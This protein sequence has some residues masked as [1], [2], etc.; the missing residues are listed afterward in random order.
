MKIYSIYKV[1]NKTNGKTYIGFDSNWPT[2][3]YQHK[4]RAKKGTIKYRLYLAINKY[5][6]N[7]FEWSI[8]YQSKELEHTLKVMEPY[9]IMEYNSMASGYN[10]TLG[11]DGTPGHLRDPKIAKEHSKRMKKHF[12]NPENRI[13]VGERM[14]KNWII[15]D[16]K[17]NKHHIKN[18]AKFCKEHNLDPGN[19]SAVAKGR[20]K[21]YKGWTIIQQ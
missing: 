19:M 6:W 14:A 18:M 9:F 1:T 15:T 11:G 4:N 2:R 16:P 5:G 8:I 3:K 12:E 10:M 20:Y 21:Q 17:G 7:N 13:K